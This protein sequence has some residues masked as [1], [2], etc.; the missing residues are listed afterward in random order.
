MN[1]KSINPSTV[2]TIVGALTVVGFCIYF[3]QQASDQ[4][5]QEGRSALYKV[6]KTFE[7]ELNAV[8]ASDR[9][10]GVP[11]DVDSKFSKTISELN[12]MI[13]AKSAPAR[14]LFEAG[15]KL[16]GIYLDHGKAEQAVAALKATTGFS[17]TGFQKASAFFLLGS[18][19]EKAKQFKE[20]LEAYQQ[21]VSQGIDAL[22]SEAM[23]GM[24]RVDLKLNEKEK[25]KLFAEKL[26]KEFPGSKPAQE[27]EALV[28]Q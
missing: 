12:G 22:R 24:V 15:L 3:Y 19:H 18:A 17:K 10:P 26:N 21:S 16:G 27:A 23:L 8:P 7:E 1:E 5:D 2:W 11:L 6:E 28:Q 4:K 20:A 14:I 9:A 25:A 13:S